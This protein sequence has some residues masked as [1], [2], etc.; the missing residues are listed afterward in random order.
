MLIKLKHCEI[1]TLTAADAPSLAQYA[2]NRKIW[3]NLR[4]AF[5]H[6]YSIK[7]AESFIKKSASLNPESNFAITINNQA[8]GCIG[9]GFHKDIERLAAEIGYWLGEPFWNK[10]IMTRVVSALTSYAITQHQLIRIY[11]VP[12]EWNTASIQ[13]LKKA[14]FKKEARMK[15]SAIKDGKIINQMLFAY[16]V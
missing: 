13:V 10:G 16:T 6:P 3:I 9:I 5:P 15:K 11:A 8:V 2:N 7:D 4:D 1:R 14:G 12:F